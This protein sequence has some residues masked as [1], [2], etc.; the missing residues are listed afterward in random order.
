MQD[1]NKKQKG[2]I[3]GY[4]LLNG[5]GC[6]NSQVCSTKC[7]CEGSGRIPSSLPGDYW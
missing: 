6:Q 4:H 2:W 5:Q 7:W 1:G 3:T